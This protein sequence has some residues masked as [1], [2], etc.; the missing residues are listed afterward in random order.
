MHGEGIEGHGWEDY[1]NQQ[2]W[3]CSYASFYSQFWDLKHGQTF[4][5]VGTKWIGISCLSS[6]SLAASFTKRLLMNE[7]SPTVHVLKWFQKC[8]VMLC[9]CSWTV[10]IV[11]FDYACHYAPFLCCF[12]TFAL[13]DIT[14]ILEESFGTS[15]ACDFGGMLLPAIFSA[16][17]ISF[18][19]AFRCFLGPFHLLNLNKVWW[20]IVKDMFL[21]IQITARNVYIYRSI[22]G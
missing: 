21:W 20:T 16:K 14:E 4:F 1:A 9:G 13:H 2:W 19:S 11:D 12:T 3:L 15:E 18:T 10:C 8:S 6:L 17:H 5:W 7:W 22:I